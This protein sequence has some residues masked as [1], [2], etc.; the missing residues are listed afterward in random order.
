MSEFQVLRVYE[1]LPKPTGLDENQQIKFVIART[2]N[3]HIAGRCR[4]PPEFGTDKWNSTFSLCLKQLKE[5]AAAKQWRRSWLTQIQNK[6]KGICKKV[7]RYTGFIYKC[8]FKLFVLTSYTNWFIKQEQ[9]KR[10]FTFEDIEL[11]VK[12][13]Y[14][15]AGRCFE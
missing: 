13:K 8:C 14:K 1:V 15:I 2:N 11:V 6:D 12:D 3:S 5:L 7:H 10:K 4:K 9:H